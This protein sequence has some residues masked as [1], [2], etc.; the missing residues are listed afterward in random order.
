MLCEPVVTCSALHG[1][2]TASKQKRV[3]AGVT[4]ATNLGCIAALTLQRRSRWNTLAHG[5]TSIQLEL[6]PMLVGFFTYKFA[7]I[8]KQFTELLSEAARSA[9]GSNSLNDSPS[10]A[11]Q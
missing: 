3:L 7:V 1:T 9:G 8:A 11:G 6:L 4:Q 5:Y 2:P 10:P